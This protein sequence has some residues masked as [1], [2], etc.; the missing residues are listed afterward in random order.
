MKTHTDVFSIMNNK[1]DKNK[2]SKTNGI[3]MF[4]GVPNKISNNIVNNLPNNTNNI[5]NTNNITNTDT[6]NIISN[7]T[8]DNAML[9]YKQKQAFK[10]MLKQKYGHLL[11]LNDYVRKQWILTNF[12][13]KYVLFDVCNLTQEEIDKIPPIYRYRCYVYEFDQEQMNNIDNEFMENSKLIQLEPDSQIRRI[14][15]ESLIEQKTYQI[16]SILKSNNIVKIPVML[17]LELYGDIPKAPIFFNNNVYYLDAKT[18]EHVTNTFQLVNLSTR[19]GERYMQMLNESKI[20]RD[21]YF[22]Q[23]NKINNSSHNTTRILQKAKNI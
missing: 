22:N 8:D 18:Q 9:E 6:K 11:E 20:M 10:Y 16:N 12:A 7:G 4:N 14:M 17:N 2:Y 23:Q 1:F 13:K 3:K 15:L 19:S 21:S 5:C